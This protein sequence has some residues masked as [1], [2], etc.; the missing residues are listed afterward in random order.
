MCGISGFIFKEGEQ[1]NIDALKLMSSVLFHRGPDYDG[2]HLSDNFGCCHTRLSIMD[3][4]EAAHQPFHDDRYVLCYNGEIYNYLELKD[5]LVTAGVEFRTT[6]DTE[7]LFY[8]LIKYGVKKALQKIKGMFA[9][10]FFDLAERTLYL[11]RDRFGIKPLYWYLKNG[12]FYWASEAKSLKAV[13]PIEIDEAKVIFSIMTPAE[14]SR[15]GSL[16]KNVNQVMPGEYI[17]YRAGEEPIL[18][19][20]FDIVD[21]VDEDYY[22]ELNN[23]GESDVIDRFSSLLED[24]VKAMLMSDAPMGVFV[25]GGI[26][27]SLLASLAIKNKSDI[28]LFTANVKDMSEFAY[29]ETLA[30]HIN[31]ELNEFPYESEMFLRDLPKAIYHYENPIMYHANSIPFSNVARL[32]SEQGIKPV[33]T[34]EGADE[35]FLGYPSI[36]YKKYA[37]LIKSPLTIISNCYRILPGKVYG[38][39][40][41]G[42][43]ANPMLRILSD[44]Q[45]GADVRLVNNRLDKGM[46]HVPKNER[47]LLKT[48]IAYMNGHLIS[49][50]HRNDRMGMM[51]SIES[52]F[53]YL[54]EEV[55]RFGV[56]LPK[57]YKARSSWNFKDIRHA[58][59]TDKYIVRKLGEKLLPKKLSEKP[60]WGFGLPTWDHI[61]VDR[62]FFKGGYLDE[63]LGF[64]FRFSEVLYDTKLYPMTIRAKLVSLDTFGRIY[65]LNQKVEDIDERYKKYIR[66]KPVH[67]KDKG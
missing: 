42:A 65:G 55:V 52:R 19:F 43:K 37:D 15:H 5:D 48:S 35:L 18:D 27:S 14:S 20:Y 33:L 8:A 45:S 62:E 38:K 25:S 34:G 2:Y 7:V 66:W 21:L 22:T 11:A 23:A 32:A 47:Q 50:L 64:N 24:S 16:F 46:G 31:A 39:I 51:S 9:F 3:L 44:L 53:P 26:D 30:K 57:R 13:V 61:E 41:Q 56:N 58:L 29:A 67:S 10:S 59:I 4:S 49:L 63:V 17:M 12:V 54:D 6:S 28:K 36:F 1:A 60:K 40:F